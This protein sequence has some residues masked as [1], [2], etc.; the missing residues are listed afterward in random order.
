MA[1][2]GRQD[3]GVGTR[4]GELALLRVEL[5]LEVLARRAAAHEN[6]GA[7]SE[8]ACERQHQ[9]VGSRHLSDKG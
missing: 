9:P 4:V 7:D 5:L 6:K 8:G 2:P 3:A 1:D